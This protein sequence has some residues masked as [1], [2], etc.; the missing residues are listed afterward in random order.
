MEFDIYSSPPALKTIETQR[1]RL[2]SRRK[3][4][5]IFSFLL[6]IVWAGTVAL[7]WHPLFPG[8][9]IEL[10]LKVALGVPA[11]M[12]VIILLTRMIGGARAAAGVSSCS[13]ATLVALIS[14]LFAMTR[15]EDPNQMYY[16]LGGT[17]GGFLLGL[18]GLIAG[19]LFNKAQAGIKSLKPVSERK[20][21]H[22]A[23]VE[24]CGKYPTL[25]EY[26]REVNLSGRPLVRGEIDAMTKWATLARAQ[27]APQPAAQPSPEAPAKAPE[28]P[29]NGGSVVEAEYVGDN[30]SN[31][32]S[33]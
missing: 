25:N 5:G 15:P 2:K 8:H 27:A 21:A 9:G 3:K 23:V 17:G 30:S 28:A 11:A 32:K 29:S 7:L 14:F 33:A 13:L 19:H 4:A 18:L 16:I 10:N 12:A 24:L 22:V 20:K 31:K 6:F 26:R 1:A